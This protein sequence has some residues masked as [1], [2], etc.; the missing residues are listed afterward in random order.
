MTE[1][2][3][4]LIHR[5]GLISA[6][7]GVIATALMLIA[8]L[9]TI[10]SWTGRIEASQRSLLSS[11]ERFQNFRDDCTKMFVTRPEHEDLKMN[12]V[13]VYQSLQNLNDK[14]DRIA[15]HHNPKDKGENSQ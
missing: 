13:R 12:I 11:Q 8:Q 9:V 4:S 2:S 3:L 15:L 14:M 10:S 7:A 6:V 5:Y 1:K